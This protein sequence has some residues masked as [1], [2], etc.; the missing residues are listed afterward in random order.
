[1]A[2]GPVGQAA[3]GSV[4]ASS[5]LP[6]AVMQASGIRSISQS[7]SPTTLPVRRSGWRMLASGFASC[8]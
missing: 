7:T 4:F 6:L 5:S 3:R 8:R 2:R 1:M